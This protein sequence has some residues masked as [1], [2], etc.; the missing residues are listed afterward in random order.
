[1]LI[2]RR[3]IYIYDRF[4]FDERHVWKRKKKYIIKKIDSW[5][6]LVPEDLKFSILNLEKI[7]EIIVFP[8]ADFYL[9]LIF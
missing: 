2:S 7:I 8:D 3:R 4:H 9:Y 5:D 6:H 1:M